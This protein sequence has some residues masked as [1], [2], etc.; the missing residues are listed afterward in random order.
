MQ[1]SF[2][3]NTI[4][5]F[6]FFSNSLFSVVCCVFLHTHFFSKRCVSVD[7]NTEQQKMAETLAKKEIAKKKLAVCYFSLFMDLAI[8]QH[9]NTRYHR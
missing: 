7:I 3:Y 9:Q 1:L 5:L 4:Y 6:L 8:K 2:A